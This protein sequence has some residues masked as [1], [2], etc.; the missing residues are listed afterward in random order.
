[1]HEW[2]CLFACLPCMC[3]CVCEIENYRMV[4][5]TH[6]S[7]GICWCPRRSVYSKWPWWPP[8]RIQGSVPA[9]IHIRTHHPSLASHQTLIQS[10][11]G[12]LLETSGS[13]NSRQSMHT[14][15]GTKNTAWSE[16]LC[17]C[18]I[19]G[20][21]ARNVPCIQQATKA[22]HRPIC[23]WMKMGSRAWGEKTRK[24]HL[25]GIGGH[26]GARGILKSLF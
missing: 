1:M 7:Q 15:R 12:H 13:L 26:W 3:L 24:T 23:S 6:S 21:R 2:A 17:G 5:S 18:V 22:L 14:Y 9:H 20:K 19:E 8:Q 11:E 4:K 10:V 16:V 25:N